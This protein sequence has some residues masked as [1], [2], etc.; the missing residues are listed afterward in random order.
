MKMHV[1]I[2][3]AG[4][5][6]RFGDDVLPKQYQKLGRQSVLAHSIEAFNDIGCQ[7]IMV[8]LHSQDNHWQRQNISSPHLLRTCQGGVS[9]QMSVIKALQA[10][11][12][13]RDDWVLV[14]DAARCCV[15]SEDI[16]KLMTQLADHSLGGILVRPIT[17]T[18]K[19]VQDHDSCERTIDRDHLV[20]ALTPQFFKFGLL[21]DA[22]QNADPEQTTD[23]ASAFEQ[24]GM[25]PGMVYGHA[26]NIKITH[27]NDLALAQFYLQQQGRL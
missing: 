8:A 21:V 14:H 23:E 7:Q 19:Y 17:D 2:V 26:D 10:L 11:D 5:G 27:A 1:V 24:K 13:E 15:R 22:L 25:R 16:E 6:A 18:V 9:R 4:T 12:A 3:A 20:A